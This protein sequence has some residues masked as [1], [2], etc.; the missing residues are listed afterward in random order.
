MQ[1][2]LELFHNEVP[3]KV[4]VKKN[5]NF[6]KNY[7]ILIFVK[8][9]KDILENVFYDKKTINNLSKFLKSNINYNKITDIKTYVF[10][11]LKIINL[12]DD[13]QKKLNSDLKEEFEKINMLK[14]NLNMILLD[15]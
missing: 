4:K 3:K 5:F 12:L 13:K 7:K 6:S 15:I 2:I 1:S 11:I 10:Y 8:I 14:N 9:Q